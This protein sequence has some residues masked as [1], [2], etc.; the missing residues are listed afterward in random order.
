M[1]MCNRAGMNTPAALF[2]FGII[3][4]EESSQSMTCGFQ[5]AK[6]ATIV[7]LCFSDATETDQPGSS[8]Q[9]RSTMIVQPL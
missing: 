1:A 5:K 8:G 9:P 7:S 6:Q 3:R 4:S 2:F